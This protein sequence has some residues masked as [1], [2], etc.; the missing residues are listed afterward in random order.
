MVRALVQRRQSG[1]HLGEDHAMHLSKKQLE[2]VIW[3]LA[4]FI[5]LAE[6]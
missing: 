5:E 2:P 3:P 4:R 6:Y 1:F